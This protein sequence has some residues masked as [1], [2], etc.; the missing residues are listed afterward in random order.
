MTSRKRAQSPSQSSEGGVEDGSRFLPIP[1]R[2]LDVAAIIEE[3]NDDTEFVTTHDMFIH[4]HQWVFASDESIV[5]IDQPL[6]NRP[7]TVPQDHKIVDGWFKKETVPLFVEKF[8][9]DAY[10]QPSDDTRYVP[11]VISSTE[12]STR[13]QGFTI[14]AIDLENQTACIP[15]QLGYFRKGATAQQ[16]SEI[17]FTIFVPFTKTRFPALTD[18]LKAPLIPL[19]NADAFQEY[20]RR[21]KDAEG[22]LQTVIRAAN[23]FWGSL[24]HVEFSMKPDTKKRLKALSEGP[25]CTT[26]ASAHVCNGY[27]SA[28][29]RASKDTVGGTPWFQGI[30]SIFTGD[31]MARVR[32]MAS[33]RKL[34]IETDVENLQIAINPPP[35]SVSDSPAKRQRTKNE[36]PGKMGLSQVYYILRDMGQ[37]P[38]WLANAIRAL[39]VLA[40]GNSDVPLMY[41]LWLDRGSTLQKDVKEIVS[42]ASREIIKSALLSSLRTEFVHMASDDSTMPLPSVLSILGIKPELQGPF[43]NVQ[44]SIVGA[45]KCSQASADNKRMGPALVASYCATHA[46]E[47]I[48]NTM[49]DEL[50]NRFKTWV[51]LMSANGFPKRVEPYMVAAFVTSLTHLAIY[52]MVQAGVANMNHFGEERGK[53]TDTRTFMK[54]VPMFQETNSSFT[55]VTNKTEK[56]AIMEAIPVSVFQKEQGVSFQAIVYKGGKLYTVLPGGVCC[57]IEGLYWYPMFQHQ[58]ICSQGVM[59]TRGLAFKPPLLLELIGS[60]VVKETCVLVRMMIHKRIDELDKPS[61]GFWNRVLWDGC[62]HIAL[63]SVGRDYKDKDKTWHDQELPLQVVDDDLGIEEFKETLIEYMSMPIPD[64]VEAYDQFPVPVLPLITKED[65]SETYTWNYDQET[66]LFMEKCRFES[67]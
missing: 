44:T 2:Y 21:I 12:E 28:Y 53:S 65:D 39:D 47:I 59:D 13:L 60:N 24:H 55:V 16:L 27:Y 45:I 35:R 11:G 25:T 38:E 46:K 34:S 57:S 9:L 19:K 52:A 51:G 20:Q 58:R 63:A 40:E 26:R 61:R 50:K 30:C 48:M 7:L 1:L 66:L 22:Y 8:L 33:S 43:V 64:D 29:I 15:G 62:P 49:A 10:T 3:T 4:V 17:K 18:A 42:R 41:R 5:F 23:K 37:Q 14:L 32:E 54:A 36:G 56:D 6:M 67:D 31:I